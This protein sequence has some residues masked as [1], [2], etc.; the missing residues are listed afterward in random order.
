MDDVKVD[1]F[2]VYLGF[3][4]WFLTIRQK[5]QLPD[6]KG[7]ICKSCLHFKHYHSLKRDTWWELLE[8]VIFPK[9]GESLPGSAL[10]WGGGIHKTLVSDERLGITERW[11]G[12]LLP[13]FPEVPVASSLPP[14]MNKVLSSMARHCCQSRLKDQVVFISLQHRNV[15][16]LTSWHVWCLIK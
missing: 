15:T 12:R 4:L 3:V 16:G 14:G 10:Q 9:L 5:N 8:L 1:H 13:Q 2:L 11:V 7:L 6:T